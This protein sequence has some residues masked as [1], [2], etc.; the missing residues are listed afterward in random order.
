VTPGAD[1]SAVTLTISR[2]TSGGLLRSGPF[3]ALWLGLPFGLVLMRSRRRRVIL[4]LLAVGLV[5]GMFACGGGG[6]A[7]GFSSQ[8]SGSTTGAT[9]TVTGTSGALSHSA[10]AQIVVGQ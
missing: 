4:L 10:T 1:S 6:G 5:A 9:V 3:V 8:T 2:T 7:S